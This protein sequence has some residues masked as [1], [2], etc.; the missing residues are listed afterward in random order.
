MRLPSWE[1]ERRKKCPVSRTHTRTHAHAHA[2]M[3]TPYLLPGTR[4]DEFAR[5]LLDF[6]FG[7]TADKK[8]TSG[9]KDNAVMNQ[10][11]FLFP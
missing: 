9:M 4:T 11:R 10:A 5:L 3:H 1:G 8:N 2:H 6:V 7:S